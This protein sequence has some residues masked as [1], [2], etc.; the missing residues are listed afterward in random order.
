MVFRNI[1]FFILVVIL[2]S[3]DIKSQKGFYDYKLVDLHGDSIVISKNMPVFVFCWATWCGSCKRRFST[4]NRLK[5]NHSETFF[6]SIP[7][8]ATNNEIKTVL[9]KH[10]LNFVIVDKTKE[11]FDNFIISQYFP[12]YSIIDRDSVLHEI[13]KN[14]NIDDIIEGNVSNFIKSK[15]I[16]YHKYYQLP[17]EEKD[18][19]Y[20]PILY[21]TLDSLLT[22]YEFKMK[23]N[24]TR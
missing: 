15:G 2:L 9:T 10:P 23:K 4:M 14:S 19:I 21:K 11:I 13:T 7:Y 17:D 12:S 18:S 5:N 1:L 22:K 16:S 6:I 3:D 24:N 20:N 8:P